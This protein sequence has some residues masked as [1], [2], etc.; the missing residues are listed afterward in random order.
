MIQINPL[1][2]I[3]ALLDRGELDEINNGSAQCFLADACVIPYLSELFGVRADAARINICL[4]EI[5]EIT[6]I[7]LLKADTDV[8]ETV[9]TFELDE[10]YTLNYTDQTRQTATQLIKSMVWSAVSDMLIYNH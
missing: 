7:T 4:G 5:P 8:F 2:V 6:R 10:E 1:T 9:G 3:G